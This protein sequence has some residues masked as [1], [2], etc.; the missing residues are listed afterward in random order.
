MYITSISEENFSGEDYTTKSDAILNGAEEWNL[1]EGDCFYIGKKMAY[2]PPTQ[3]ARDF[4]YDM[5]ERDID[6]LGDWSE[7]WETTLLKKQALHEKIEKKLN[8]I[9]DLIM[10]D[11]KPDF[12]LVEDVEK[13][14]V[15][16]TNTA[17]T[18]EQNAVNR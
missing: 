3:S 5:I 12:W 17:E 13:I 6:R 2:T 16:N 4:L 15:N 10:E 1:G 8:E 9:T 18:K 11:H 14:F 7:Y